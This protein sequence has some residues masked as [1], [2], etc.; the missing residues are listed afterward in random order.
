M[1]LIELGLIGRSYGFCGPNFRHVHFHDSWKRTDGHSAIHKG[2]LVG[3]FD[4][5]DYPRC[6]YDFEVP[7]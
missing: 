7:Y 3:Y 1:G 5:L 2:S 4:A 6:I